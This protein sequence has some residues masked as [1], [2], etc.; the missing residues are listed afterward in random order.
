[1]LNS[2]INN[3][4]HRLCYYIKQWKIKGNLDIINDISEHVTLVQ[5]MDRIGNMNHS[6]IIAFNCMFDSNCENKLH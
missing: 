5:L 1:M 2:A 3:G 6:V 4:Y